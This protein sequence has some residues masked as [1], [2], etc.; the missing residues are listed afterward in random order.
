MS[1]L[2]VHMLIK[3]EERFVWF[4]V[5]SVIN[6]VDKLIIFDSG[7][8]DKTLSIVK[9][10]NSPKII[11]EEKGE[12]D[13]N[14]LVLL[15]NEMVQ[16]TDTEWFLLVDGDEVWPERSLKNLTNTISKLSPECWGV[17][18]RTRNCVGDI[19]HYQPE[20]AGKY[21]LLGRRGHLSIRA[22]RKMNGFHWQ[23]EYPNEAYSDQQKFPIN[24]QQNHLVFEDVA[25]WHLTHLKRSSKPSE[26]IDRKSKFKLEAGIKADKKEIP[27]VFFHN[28]PPGIPSPRKTP[29]LAQKILIYLI[30][31]LRRLKR[32]FLP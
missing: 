23:G 1:N 27:E 15:R 29:S 24:N 9:N 32:K 14:G 6:E 7:S 11:L 30:T 21:E 28:L 18:V 2:T 17:V 19:F 5:N 16:K 12:Q 22:Y 10:I 20:S 3:N 31:P 4:A 25:Y 13:R 8:T 26:V